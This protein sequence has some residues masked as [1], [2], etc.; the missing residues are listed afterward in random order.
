MMLYR[1]VYMLNSG[2]WRN[3]SSLLCICTVPSGLLYN[4]RRVT[5]VGLVGFTARNTYRYWFKPP[6]CVFLITG[7]VPTQSLRT[8][9]SCICF[10]LTS[11]FFMFFG[12]AFIS[13]KL[14]CNFYTWTRICILN[15][16]PRSIPK[17]SYFFY[18]SLSFSNNCRLSQRPVDLTVTTVE[19]FCFSLWE[20]LKSVLKFAYG[21]W[22]RYLLYCHIGCVAL[23]H[24]LG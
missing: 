16:D 20:L 11:L 22:H 9:I 17:P 3:F 14:K 24:T 10:A 2:V 12:F 5:F 19:L 18:Q 7:T 8:L 13:A 23:T 1:V 15:G 4:R 21:I 6:L